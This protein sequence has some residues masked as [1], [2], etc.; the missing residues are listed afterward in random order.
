MSRHSIP[1]FLGIVF[2]IAFRRSQRARALILSRSSNSTS[3]FRNFPVSTFELQVAISMPRVIS[4]WTA[5]EDIEQPVSF[6]H[7]EASSRSLLRT[8]ELSPWGFTCMTFLTYQGPPIGGEG[9]LPSVEYIDLSTFIFAAF[10]SLVTHALHIV[11]HLTLRYNSTII[12]HTALAS[13]LPPPV[14]PPWPPSKLSHEPQQS[15]SQMA[16]DP[17]PAERTS[18]HSDQRHLREPPQHPTQQERNENSNTSAAPSSP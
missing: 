7:A 9:E 6:V 15:P 13:A 16:R 5:L 10:I 14:P 17:P 8:S 18:S 12:R 1:R 4:K 3:E 11:L 2:S